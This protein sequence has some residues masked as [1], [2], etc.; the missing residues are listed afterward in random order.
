MEDPLWCGR[1]LFRQLY[2]NNLDSIP[3]FIS[4]KPM[5]DYYKEGALLWYSLYKR[6]KS[7][8]C[9]TKKD[10]EIY[11]SIDMAKRYQVSREADKLT[12]KL[13]PGIIRSSGPILLLYKEKFLSFIGETEGFMDRLFRTF[14]R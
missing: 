12:K 3:E 8:F 11:F 1:E 9:V 4:D 14:R 2:A 5:G 7:I 13:P 6:E 10:G